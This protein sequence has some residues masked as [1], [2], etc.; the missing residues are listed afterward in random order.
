M[1]LYLHVPFIIE[2]PMLNYSPME[3][4]KQNKSINMLSWKKIVCA[5]DC[6]LLWSVLF[7]YEKTCTAK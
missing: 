6:E 2:L 7:R 5:G 4:K 1:R 3:K